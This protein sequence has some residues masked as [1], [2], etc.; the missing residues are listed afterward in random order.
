MLHVEKLG[1]AIQLVLGKHEA[2]E[3]QETS[4]YQ[5]VAT[6][7][8]RIMA[9]QG[10]ADARIGEPVIVLDREF[11]SF[12]RLSAMSSITMRRLERRKFVF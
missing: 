10:K 12:R 1:D 2:Q 7:L 6:D 11:A 5:S 9:W 3:A 4:R 8:V